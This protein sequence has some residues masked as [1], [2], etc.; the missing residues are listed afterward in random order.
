MKL[1]NDYANEKLFGTAEAR[2]YG[3]NAEEFGGT[4][5]LIN[6]DAGYVGWFGAKRLVGIIPPT[7]PAV[8]NQNN[9][10]SFA[11]DA[12]I[13]TKGNKLLAIGTTLTKNSDTTITN[14]G[15]LPSAAVEFGYDADGDFHDFSLYLPDRK[16]STTVSSVGTSDD[17]TDNAP[18]ADSGDAPNALGFSKASDEFDF[19]ADY[20]ARIYWRLDKASHGYDGYGYAITGFETDSNNIPTTGGATFTGKGEGQYYSNNS[21]KKYFTVTATANFATR[22]INLATTHTDTNYSYLNLTGTLNYDEGSNGITGAVET[23]GTGTEASK[24][25]GTAEARFYGPAAEEFGGVFSTSNQ[26]GTAGFNG[27]FGA[28]K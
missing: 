2:F 16:Y 3:P 19:T 4:F 23:T 14:D 27:Y 8:F 13:G 24:L 25:K 17:I 28:K 1:Q 5:S 26:D 20:M 9:L 11:D 12:R 18:V 6:D 15:F 22:N 21:S 7:A 10:A